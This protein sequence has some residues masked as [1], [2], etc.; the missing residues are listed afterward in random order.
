M[1]VWWLVCLELASVKKQEP[2]KRDL[3][4]CRSPAQMETISLKAGAWSV[5]V[6]S[7]CLVTQ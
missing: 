5:K 2:V 4:Q 3:G 1:L 6:L 7:V